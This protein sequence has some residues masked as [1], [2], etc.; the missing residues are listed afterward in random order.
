MKKVVFLSVF[1]FFAITSFA[2]KVNWVGRN[3]AL[4]VV[5]GKI[6]NS[7]N[8]QPQLRGV[9]LSWSIWEGKNIITRML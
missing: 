4:K 6:L 1:V 5:D 8:I 3:G 2:Q 9:S 7:K